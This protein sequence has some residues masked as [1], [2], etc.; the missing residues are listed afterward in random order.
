MNILVVAATPFEIAPLLDYL[1]AN[2]K[3]DSSIVFSKNPL[4]IHVLVTGIGLTHTAYALGR[5]IGSTQIDWAINLGIAGALDKNLELGK[6]VVVEE[7]AFADLGIEQ[8][9]GSFQDLFE[10]EL[11]EANQ[12]PFK[13]KNLVNTSIDES[14]F[15]TKVKGISVNKVH[16]FAPSIEKI[17]SYYPTA[18]IESMEGAAFHFVC[19]QEKIPFLQIRSISNYVETRDKSN[20]NIPLAIEELNKVA[21]DIL[22][23][24]T[25]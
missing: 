12:A 5:Y 7:D 9:D 10:A 25:S 18:Q 15:L 4:K 20:W 22:E 14:Q 16:G 8:A 1:N 6:V 11:F 21:I 13:D 24:F 2:F 23:S 3:K 17:K 19:L